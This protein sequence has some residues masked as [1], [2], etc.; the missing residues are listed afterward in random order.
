M[1]HI[2]ANVHRAW[3]RLMAMKLYAFRAIDYVHAASA[4]DRRYL[5]F[6]AVQKAKVSTEGLKVMSLLQECVG[7]KGFESTGYFEMALRDIQLIPSLEGSMHINLGL[8]V[9]FIPRYFDRSDSTLGQP[10]SL[11][12]GEIRSRENPYLMEA[13]AGS[14]HAVGFCPYLD[15]YGLLASSNAVAPFL[16]Q[17]QAFREIATAR[18]AGNVETSDMQF[19]MAL[20]QCFATIVYGQLIAENA[21]RLNVPEAM[22]S[23]VFAVLVEDLS[24]LALRLAA[25]P[26]ISSATRKSL[27][28]MI[29]VPNAEGADGSGTFF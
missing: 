28:G 19:E 5:L 21:V 4:S 16:R 9:Q 6:C 1:R 22:T 17:V 8:A 15:A 27:S 7:A 14:P 12:G 10:P 20:G 29:E 25:I 24:T 18:S 11:A 2:E 13:R 26:G 23:S 3:V